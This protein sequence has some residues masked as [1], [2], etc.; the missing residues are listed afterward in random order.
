V[1]HPHVIA[2]PHV[3]WHTGLMFRQTGGA[4]AANLQRYERGEQPLWVVNSPQYRR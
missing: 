3:G 4:F 1:R 2:T